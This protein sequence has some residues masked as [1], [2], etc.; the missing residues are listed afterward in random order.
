MNSPASIDADCAP[1]HDYSMEKRVATRTGKGFALTEGDL[2]ILKFIHEYRLLRIE[3]VARLTERT[4]TRVHRRMKGLFDV[5]FLRRIEIPQRKDIYHL[6]RPALRLLLSRGLITDVE[7]ERRSR[8]HELKPATLDHEMMIADIHVALAKT[9]ESGSLKLAS[10]KEGEEIR[11][12]FQAGT[13]S[14]VIQPDAFFQIKDMRLPDGQN[15]RTFLLEADRST[16]G[17]AQRSGSQRFRDKIERYRWFIDSG[18]AFDRYGVRSIRILTLT[19]TRERR[20]N[21][22]ADTDAFLVGHNL[23]R[24]RKFFLFGA[25]PDMPLEKGGAI[26]E[27]L[28]HRPGGAAPYPLFPSLAENG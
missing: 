10:W 5:G 4:Y 16:M 21:L 3:Q 28:F 25:L 1:A 7:A 6:G 22:C 14:L 15:R 18:Q 12:R 20:D 8:E 11:H 26:L 19:L 27:P 17:I 23:I 24:L 13:G 2:A 9:A